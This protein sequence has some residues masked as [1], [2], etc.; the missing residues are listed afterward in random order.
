M[1]RAFFKYACSFECSFEQNI[2]LPIESFLF[3]SQMHLCLLLGGSFGLFQEKKAPK[4]RI[5]HVN[6]SEL[7]GK[8]EQW[9]FFQIR[10][11][12]ANCQGPEDTATPCKSQGSLTL[13]KRVYYLFSRAIHLN[14]LL[15]FINKLRFACSSIFLWSTCELLCWKEFM[16]GKESLT[17][18]RNNFS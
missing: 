8:T 11:M 3:I 1:A 16:G 14:V 7:L 10:I 17:L 5:Q 2:Y 13:I 18:P 9:W 6:S 12:Y 4:N 15:D